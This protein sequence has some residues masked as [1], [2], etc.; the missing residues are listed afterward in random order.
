MVKKVAEPHFMELPSTC[1]IPVE[2]AGH[3]DN[4]GKKGRIIAVSDCGRGNGRIVINDHTIVEVKISQTLTIRT[5]IDCCL[6]HG[7]VLK[8]VESFLSV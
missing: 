3:C 4:K 5:P 6:N 2:I 1:Y 7:A 8:K